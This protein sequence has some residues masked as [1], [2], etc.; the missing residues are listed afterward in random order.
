[1]DWWIR[2]YVFRISKYTKRSKGYSDQT[3]RDIS[4][5]EVYAFTWDKQI[6]KEEN[7]KNTI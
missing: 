5:C 6:T 1:M 2:D 7:D 4:G 3:C